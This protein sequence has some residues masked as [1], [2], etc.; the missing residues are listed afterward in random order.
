MGYGIRELM[1]ENVVF[2][3]LVPD[4]TLK[5]TSQFVWKC[6]KWSCW[7]RQHEIRTFFKI[8]LQFFLSKLKINIFLT[9]SLFALKWKC[10]ISFTLGGRT[11]LKLWKIVGF[12]IWDSFS[13]TQVR[14]VCKHKGQFRIYVLEFIHSFPN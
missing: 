3:S 14:C 12:L 7:L 4:T 10:Y 5:P 2:R 6:K 11:S 9:I 1:V 8:F 13:N